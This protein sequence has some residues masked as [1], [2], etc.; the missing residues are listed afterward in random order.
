VN[1]CE[2]PD[3]SLDDKKKKKDA[4]ISRMS[5]GKHTDDDPSM[6]ALLPCMHAYAIHWHLKAETDVSE[7]ADLSVYIYRQQAPQALCIAKQPRKVHK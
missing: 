5:F 6:D 4:H 3:T 2:P 1:A 7:Q